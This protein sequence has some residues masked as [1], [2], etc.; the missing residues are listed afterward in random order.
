MCDIYGAIE[1]LM[2]TVGNINTDD[3]ENYKICIEK[4][5]VK[6]FIDRLSSLKKLKAGNDDE[7]IENDINGLIE[8]YK[9]TKDM[10][11]KELEVD[12]ITIRNIIYNP[13]EEEIGIIKGSYPNYEFYYEITVKGDPIPLECESISEF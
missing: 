8:K 1:L 11:F 7:Q 4:K 6:N 13:D 12:N 2:D 10:F 5:R 9:N 3:K